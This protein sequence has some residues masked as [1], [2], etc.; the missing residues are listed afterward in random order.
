MCCFYLL[1]FFI[2]VL[3]FLIL[4]YVNLMCSACEEIKMVF[5]FIFC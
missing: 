4:F 1:A 5:N 2:G 3:G